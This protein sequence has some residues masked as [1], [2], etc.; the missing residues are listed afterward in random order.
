MSNQGLSISESSVSVLGD[1]KT[2]TDLTHQDEYQLLTVPAAD[3]SQVP[4]QQNGGFVR[5]RPNNHL[6]DNDIRGLFCAIYR[7]RCGFK[8]DLF[9]TDGHPNRR[10]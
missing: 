10:S 8:A 5:D 1:R 9:T 7:S 3:G 2:K 6:Y 4:A